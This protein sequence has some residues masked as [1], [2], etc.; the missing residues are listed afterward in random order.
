MKVFRNSYNKKF[1]N[2]VPA[3]IPR[4]VFYK[5]KQSIG[6]ISKPIVKVNDFVKEGE[7]IA[8]SEEFMAI[9]LHSS[10][11]GKVTSI[12]H[13]SN[14]GYWEIEI[15]YEGAIESINK[16]PEE[17]NNL[18]VEEIL[19]RIRYSGIVDKINNIPVY[20]LLNTADYLNIKNIH[21]SNTGKEKKASLWLY[22]NM[23]KVNEIKYGIKILNKLLNLKQINY[24]THFSFKNKLGKIKSKNVKIKFYNRRNELH[25]NV[26]PQFINNGYNIFSN[27]HPTITNNSLLLSV[28]T[29]VLLYEAV[30]LN[31]PL[32]EK[33]I[34]VYGLNTRPF[35]YKV[36][37]GMK[38]LD[39]LEDYLNDFDKYCVLVNSYNKLLEVDDVV[40]YSID[41]GIHEI[42]ILEKLHKDKY[43]KEIEMNNNKYIEIT[44]PD[45]EST[46]IYDKE[47][48]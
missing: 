19:N 18:S 40:N 46:L 35:I 20:N 48:F 36:R 9:G 28:E 38:L 45:G 44:L 30:L 37:I 21:I 34:T 11:P 29:V 23:N 17:I 24:L 32:I 13:V 8:F 47:I 6:K 2:I 43:I 5:T 16:N 12:N 27:S 41:K 25:N 42:I 15:E 3:F 14:L 26:K 4:K 22:Y 10:I 7:L 39:L 31:K 33:I 1:E